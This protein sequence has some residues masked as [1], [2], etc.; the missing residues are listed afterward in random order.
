MLV[1]SGDFLKLG[2]RNAIV[3]S[4]SASQLVDDWI[5]LNVSNLS[6]AFILTIALAQDVVSLSLQLQSHL[7][8]FSNVV[9]DFIN[10]NQQINDLLENLLLSP[11]QDGLG[12]E[13]TQVRAHSH[14]LGLH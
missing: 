13:E 6:T 10:L 8:L 5:H 11:N 9:F 14:I 4:L 2:H 7:F 1:F 12:V 3:I